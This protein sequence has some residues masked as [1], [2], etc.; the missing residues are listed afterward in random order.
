MSWGGRCQNREGAGDRQRN[1]QQGGRTKPPPRYLMK[2]RQ[3]LPIGEHT[4]P[5]RPSLGRTVQAIQTTKPRIPRLIPAL[6]ATAR[7]NTAQPSIQYEIL[8]LGEP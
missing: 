5:G 7:A 6:R 3:E 1:T 8:T 2:P 4:Q